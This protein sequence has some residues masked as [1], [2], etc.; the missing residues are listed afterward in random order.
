MFNM[1]TFSHAFTWMLSCSLFEFFLLYWY[2]KYKW[3]G[4]GED[5]NVFWA[6]L[7]CMIVYVLY[8]ASCWWCTAWTV[9]VEN[10][11]GPNCLSLEVPVIFSCILSVFESELALT[12]RIFC[13]CWYVVMSVFCSQAPLFAASFEAVLS[14]LSQASCLPVGFD[15]V[16]L[17]LICVCIDSN[18]SCIQRTALIKIEDS[19]LPSSILSL[20][21]ACIPGS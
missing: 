12:S 11:F 19:S 3:S 18:L 8:T 17:Q 13:Y 4:R 16:Q 1:P 20:W 2:F 5:W 6:K 14:K 10:R 7:I 9:T 21:C 15:Y